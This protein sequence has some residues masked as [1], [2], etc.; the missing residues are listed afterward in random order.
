MNVT[1]KVLVVQEEYRKNKYMKFVD[2]TI[3]PLDLNLPTERE[4]LIHIGIIAGICY[5]SSMDEEKCIKRAISCIRR[6]HHSPWEHIT[7]TLSNIIDRGTSHALIRHRHCAFQQS[8]T[9]YQKYNELLIIGQS[10][11]TEAEKS[12]YKD[13]EAVYLLEVSK[14]QMPPHRVRDILPNALVT[15]LIITTNMR[16]WQYMFR[17]RC[18]Y[19]D[20]ENMHKWATTVQEWFRKNYPII[21][22]A[23]DQFYEE[24][25]ID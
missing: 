8:S 15:D 3:R 6:G 18:G 7:F 1:L 25:P 10:N 9:I 2:I 14:K 5:A 19:G 17:R 16:Q 22:E 11:I 21:T 20:S 4:L 13:I 12:L 23:F 24:H